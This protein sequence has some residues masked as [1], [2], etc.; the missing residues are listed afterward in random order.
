MTTKKE[1][2][3]RDILREKKPRVLEK[4]LEHEH[5]QIPRI[6]LQWR[7][8]CNFSCEHC[9]VSKIKPDLGDLLTYDDI[10]NL[11][12]Q[13]DDLGI[14]RMTISGGEPLLFDLDKL[15]TAIDPSKFWIQLDTNAWLM[16]EDK[17]KQLRY[18]S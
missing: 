4:I 9:S 11:F 7:Y 10:K 18:W 17:I 2:T 16:T 5:E 3:G 12:S 1:K 6:Q 14:S 8:N 15:V 13:A